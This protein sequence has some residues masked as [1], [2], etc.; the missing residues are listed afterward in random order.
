MSALDAW[1]RPL[2]RITCMVRHVS[3]RR[4]SGFV[5]RLDVLE[6]RTLPSAGAHDPSFGGS[7]VVQFDTGWHDNF[8]GVALQPDGKVIAAGTHSPAASPQQM[9]VVRYNR[10]GTPDDGGA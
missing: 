8:G 10:D 7:G 6:E 1:R 4:A 3:R 5:P 9:V 2:S